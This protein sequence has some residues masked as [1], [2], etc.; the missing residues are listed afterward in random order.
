MGKVHRVTWEKEVGRGERTE[1]NSGARGHGTGVGGGYER[2]VRPPDKER[3]LKRRARIHQ[4]KQT[5]RRGVG[6]RGGLSF[7]EGKWEWGGGAGVGP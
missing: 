2:G 4:K 6:G 1:K 5:T 7:W 3:R